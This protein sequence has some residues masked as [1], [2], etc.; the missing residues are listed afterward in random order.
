MSDGRK[1]LSGAEYRKKAKLKQNEQQHALQKTRKIESFFKS[2]NNKETQETLS[3]AQKSSGTT[4]ITKE[5][6]H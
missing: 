2:D 5:D 4:S 3:V 1:R 6:Q